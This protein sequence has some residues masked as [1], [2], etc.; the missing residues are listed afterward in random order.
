MSLDV[1]H[2]APPGLTVKLYKN[3]HGLNTGGY[4]GGSAS[5]PNL[6]GVTPIAQGTSNDLGFPQFNTG[7]S[8]YVPGSTRTVAGLTVD[9]NNFTA[10]YTGYFQ[11]TVSGLW[12]ICQSADDVSY[13]YLGSGSAF[14]CGNPSDQG[15]TALSSSFSYAPV[16]RTRTLV[17]GLLYPYR[18]VFG[19]IQGYSFLNVS[20]TPP[21]GTVSSSFPGYLYPE[22]SSCV[23]GGGSTTSSTSSTTALTPVTVT[24]TGSSTGLTTLTPGPSG[25]PPTVVTFVTPSA[26]PIPPVTVTSTGSSTG[27]TTLA[28]G[29]SGGPTTVVTFVTPT[30]T[31]VTITSTGTTTGLTTIPQSG[32][33]PGTVITIACR[34]VTQTQT[35]SASGAAGTQASFV[36]PACARTAT[37]RIKGG[38]GGGTGRE[39]GVGELILGSLAVTPGQT[40]VAIAGGAGNINIQGTSAYGNGGTAVDGGGGGGGASAILIGGAEVVVAGGGGGGDIYLY[41]YPTDGRPNTVTITSDANRG[42]GGSPGL[43]GVGRYTVD[44]GNTGTTGFYN[45]A[46]GG[47]GGTA[48]GAG[49]GGIAGGTTTAQANGNAGSGHNGGAG[50]STR[51]TGSP[52]SGGSGAGGGGYFGGGSGSVLDWTY[53]NNRVTFGGGGGG[54]SSFVRSGVTVSSRSVTGGTGSVEIVFTS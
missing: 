34:T 15:G 26:T 27:L 2:Y 39:S 47:G 12:T 41:G 7:T 46:R 50:L 38:D 36:V 24:S 16:C 14:S 32:T 3:N 11:P 18:E 1:H 29:P 52:G 53:G 30:P 33:V 43:Q 17:A 10:L 25:G 23:P 45:V 31:T 54:G 42:Q 13:L 5:P 21:G 8:D 37:F 22:D 48:T 49:A 6:N 51:N 20:F 9:A 35:I 44:E 28:P 40:Y 19:Q 4:Q